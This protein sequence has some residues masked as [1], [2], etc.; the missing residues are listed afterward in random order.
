[1]DL[2]MLQEGI[3]DL[4]RCGSKN[5]QSLMEN[6]EKAHKELAFVLAKRQKLTSEF[7]ALENLHMFEK[8]MEDNKVCIYSKQVAYLKNLA[9]TLGVEYASQMAAQD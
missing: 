2:A 9:K 5:V 3:K 8:G 4:H 1:M 7:N 6:L